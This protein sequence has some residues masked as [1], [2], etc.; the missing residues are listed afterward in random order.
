MST[1]K[2]QQSEPTRPHDIN[3]ALTSRRSTKPKV[4]RPRSVAALAQKE[5]FAR[6][7]LRCRSKRSAE[8]HHGTNHG[9]NWQLPQGKVNDTDQDVSASLHRI[10]LENA[11][12]HIKRI[13]GSQAPVVVLDWKQDRDPQVKLY[14][15]V[16][17]DEV[18]SVN[19]LPVI[20]LPNDSGYKA[21]QWM[22]SKNDIAKLK[23]MSECHVPLVNYA[24]DFRLETWHD[25]ATYLSIS[26]QS[27][28]YTDRYEYILCAAVIRPRQAVTNDN[29][30]NVDA[31][32]SV[33]SP[34]ALL[35]IQRAATETG[36]LNWELPGGRLGEPVQHSRQLFVIACHGR[37]DLL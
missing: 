4:W 36:P 25:T 3:P 8:N 9:T 1:T 15:V 5:E 12:L 29:V 28:P 19:D 7:I 30:L 18:S 26:P 24:F 22:R 33:K 2:C 31:E 17:V 10:V 14:F 21:A 37:Q 23:P 34:T 27:L 35:L 11:G 6:A 13:I 16:T 32:K 20:S